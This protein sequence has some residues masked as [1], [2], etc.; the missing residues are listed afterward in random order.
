M[1]VARRRGLRGEIC[2][3][4]RWQDLESSIPMGVRIHFDQGHARSD[5]HEPRCATL[6][7]AAAAAAGDEVLIRCIVLRPIATRIRTPSG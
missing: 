4:A 3:A 5:R 7:P 6:A 2:R 1:T